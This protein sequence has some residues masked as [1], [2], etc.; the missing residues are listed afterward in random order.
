MH[1]FL[2]ISSIFSTYSSIFPLYFPHIPSYFPHIPSYFLHIPKGQYVEGS[3]EFFPVEPI[4]RKQLE[5][6]YLAPRFA[7]CFANRLYS[8]KKRKLGIFPSPRAY[9]ERKRSE[10]F[11]HILSYFPH[12]PSYFPHIPSYFSHIPKS[13][14]S[15]SY[16]FIFL[17]YFYLFPTYF[18][19]NPSYFPHI[20]SYFS[21]ILSYFSH[22]P[23]SLKSGE[24]GGLAFHEFTPGVQGS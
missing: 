23:K 9:I 20:L 19:H 16:A 7:R 2:H 5:R 6:W 22:I 15:G 12:I 11:P 3:L 18:P 13:L 21:H 24:G 4:W 17:S 1:I 8:E 14:K 10:F